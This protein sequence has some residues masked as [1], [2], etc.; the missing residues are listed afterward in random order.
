MNHQVG[1]HQLGLIPP[2]TLAEQ[3]CFEVQ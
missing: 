2:T 3:R 1:G